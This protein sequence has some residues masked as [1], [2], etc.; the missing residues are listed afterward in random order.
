MTTNRLKFRFISRFRYLTTSL[1]MARH[2]KLILHWRAMKMI[3]KE[4]K[5]LRARPHCYIRFRSNLTLKGHKTPN[6]E[7]FGST[8]YR[9]C[10]SEGLNEGFVNSEVLTV[11]TTSVVVEVAVS[12]SHGERDSHLD[13][14]VRRALFR[15]DDSGL[16]HEI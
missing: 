6:R 4:S 2:H 7:R 8:I 9:D 15:F 10:K 12:S 16:G 11:V 14:Q 1:Y 13:D 5:S 3:L